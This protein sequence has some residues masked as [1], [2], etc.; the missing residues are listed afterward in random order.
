MEGQTWCIVLR[1]SNK[2][3]FMAPTEQTIDISICLLTSLDHKDN[4]KNVFGLNPIP[5]RLVF[6][7]QYF[8]YIVG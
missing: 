8:I 4:G 1:V 7:S 3:T 6:S 2:I 5:I